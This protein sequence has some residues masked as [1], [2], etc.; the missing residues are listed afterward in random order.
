M[1]QHQVVNARWD[2]EKGVW[3]IR[4]QNL[5]TGELFD[6]WCHFLIGASGILK[7]YPP[8]SNSGMSC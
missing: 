2:E 3:R 5:Q 1:L 6:D 8:T 4:V 7:Y